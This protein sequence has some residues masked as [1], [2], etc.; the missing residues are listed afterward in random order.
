MKKINKVI[1]SNKMS[2]SM[3]MSV[4]KPIYMDFKNIRV[5]RQKNN[6]LS[7]IN[8]IINNNKIEFYKNINEKELERTIDG[9]EITFDEFWKKCNEDIMFAKLAAGCISNCA[10]RQGTTD[11]TEQIKICNF[12]SQ[13]CGINITNLTTTAIR[14]TK[15]GKIITKE[16]MKQKCIKKDC[17]LKS[18]DGIITGKINGYIAA[19]VAFGSG[20][21]QDNVLEEMDSLAKWWSIYKWNFDEYLIIIIDTDLLFKL[22]SIKNKY[23][24]INNIKIFNHY[25]FQE[26]IIINY[27]KEVE[28]VSI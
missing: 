16:E 11:E 4:P 9:L 7:V 13:L 14:P 17:C 3:S 24:L 21:H 10:S 15:D 8:C 28:D 25:E 22:S 27:Y 19:K 6:N 1:A 12:I 5:N 20:G 23:E 18:F 2:M 26:Y